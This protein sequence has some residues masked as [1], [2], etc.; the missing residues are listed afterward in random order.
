M[1]VAIRRRLQAKEGAQSLLL[2]PPVRMRKNIFPLGLQKATSSFKIVP[3]FPA[4]W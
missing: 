1:G 4:S 2:S 3:A